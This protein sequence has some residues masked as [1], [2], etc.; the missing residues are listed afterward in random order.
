[1]T[2][3]R[4]YVIRKTYLEGI[5]KGSSCIYTNGGHVT[6]D[7]KE[8]FIFPDKCYSTLSTAKAAITRYYKEQDRDIRNNISFVT[9]GS[10]EPVEVINGHIV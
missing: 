8:T 2:N 9:K 1:M 5:H 10:Y 6:S 7:S 3:W 4:G